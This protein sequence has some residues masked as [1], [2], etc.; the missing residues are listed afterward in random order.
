MLS[1]VRPPEQLHCLQ[2]YPSQVVPVENC[3]P[4]PWEPP[5]QVLVL[6]VIGAERFC[7]MT[8]YEQAAR[9]DISENTV[10]QLHPAFQREGLAVLHLP[11]MQEYPQV[12]S[13]SQEGEQN[14]CHEHCTEVRDN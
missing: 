3:S 9:Q 10:L 6:L 11:T 13:P 14:L 7:E 4:V 2:K 12:G 5:E 1:R 8:Q